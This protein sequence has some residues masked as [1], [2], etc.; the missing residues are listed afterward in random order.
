MIEISKKDV[1]NITVS[2][3][4][5]RQALHLGNVDKAWQLLG[6]PFMLSGMVVKGQQIGSTIG[7]P[8]AN[9]KLTDPNKLVPPD[10]IYAVRI[11][12]DLVTYDG[13]MYIGH[14]PTLHDGLGKSIEVGSELPTLKYDS[15]KTTDF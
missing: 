8:T 14:R 15:V 10:G 1:S 12:I 2:S 4:K 13:M 11:S 3:T 6:H 9:I 5:V 7:F